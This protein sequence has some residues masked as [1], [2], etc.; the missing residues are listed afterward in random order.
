MDDQDH[1]HDLDLGRAETG[2][3]HTD[4]VWK[5][6]VAL[7]GIYAFFIMEQMVAILTRWKRRKK[8]CYCIENCV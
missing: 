8:V 6:L 2:H 5:G 4:A 7:A 1:S 3:D